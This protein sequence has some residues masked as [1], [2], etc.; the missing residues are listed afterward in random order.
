ML[1]I[2]AD[3]RE[4]FG[5]N[6]LSP[7]GLFVKRDGF[8]GWRG[9]PTGRREAL[10]RAV[11]HGE[12]DV[13]TFL[14]ARIVTIDGLLVA[15]SEE[16]LE[17]LSDLVTGI[18]ATGKRFRTVVKSRGATRW[19]DG[20][21]LLC[22]AEDARGGSLE[23]GYQLQMVFADPRRYGST[24]ALP[25]DMLSPQNPAATATRI[26]VFSR[27][28]FPAY[29]VIEIPSAPGAYTVSSPGGAFTVSGATPGGTHTVDLRSGRVYRDGVEMP[30]VGHGNLWA[31]PS[32]AQ[33]AHV[34][35]VPGR[36]LINDT[37][38]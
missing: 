2:S 12:H 3:G 28:N 17:D 19:A 16:H 27:G 7:F 18:G 14:P 38:I 13:P 11:E 31:V 37:Y 9:L 30:G 4:I 23:T 10:A 8:Q 22:E 20:R 26:N 32:G 36:V 21:R 15:K 35:S 29:P 34:L 5:D 24:N 1:E 33:W 6:R 25:G